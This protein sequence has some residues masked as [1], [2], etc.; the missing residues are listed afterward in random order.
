MFTI[1]TIES[2]IPPP[3]PHFVGDG[4]RVHNF[5]PGQIPGGMKRTDPFLL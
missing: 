4:F 1:R 5:F 3:P 2:I